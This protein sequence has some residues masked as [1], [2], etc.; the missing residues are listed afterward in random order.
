MFMLRTLISPQIV[1]NFRPLNGL[2]LQLPIF[3]YMGLL[4]ENANA[5]YSLTSSFLPYYVNY[6]NTP[7]SELCRT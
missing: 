7:F 5:S 3:R 6:G 2:R 1:P 4:L